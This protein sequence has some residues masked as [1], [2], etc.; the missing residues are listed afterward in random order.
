MVRGDYATHHTFAIS[1]LLRDLMQAPEYFLRDHVFFCV[2][3]T[4]C[5]FLDLKA[6]KYLCTETHTFERLA[7]HLHGW[8]ISAVIGARGRTSLTQEA[9]CL[10]SELVSQDILSES[11][12]D[13]KSAIPTS[14]EL[15][16]KRFVTRGE[17]ASVFYNLSRIPSFFAATVRANRRLGAQPL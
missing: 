12:T 11:P 8:P 13:C 9:R 4:F 10:A 3:E 5:L 17:P 14:W 6:D 2:S 1:H 16:S 7:P 15:P